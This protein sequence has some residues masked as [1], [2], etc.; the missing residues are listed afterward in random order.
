M[1]R[2]RQNIRRAFGLLEAEH[3]SGIE[4][5]C[6]RIS[7]G[8][9]GL[10]CL[11]MPDTASKNALWQRKTFSYRALALWFLIPA[12]QISKSSGKAGPPI[13]FMPDTAVNHAFKLF[14]FSLY[15]A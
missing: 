3:P 5:A 7:V 15:R 1:G 10:M 13:A 2:L 14:N 6:A 8:H 11:I 4:A 12:R 9:L